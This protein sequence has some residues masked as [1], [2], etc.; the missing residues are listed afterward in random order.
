MI[1]S[2]ASLLACYFID[3]WVLLRR[4][5]VT[6]A[7]GADLSYEM[8]DLLEWFLPL[9]CLANIFFDYLIVPDT[10]YAT[11]KDTKFNF[12]SLISIFD[13][14]S[15]YSIAGLIIGFVHSII[16][17]H[18]LNEELFSLDD[19][20]LSIPFTKAAYEN[21]KREVKKQFSFN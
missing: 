11:Y 3:K 13:N 21:I 2:V 4:R 17:T 9:F 8:I 18:A 7:L 15:Y 20:T 14:A 16:P 1:Y 5:R 12:H 6:S 10:D 19:I